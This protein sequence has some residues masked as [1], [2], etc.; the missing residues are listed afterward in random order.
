MDEKKTTTIDQH[1]AGMPTADG[2][3]VAA[4]KS[5]P[6]VQGQPG[7]SG[8]SGSMLNFIAAKASDP[9]CDAGQLKILLE[10]QRM[11]IADD[12]REQFNAALILV[13]RT[14]PKVSKRGTIEMGAKGS[15]PFARWEDV[16]AVTRPILD[17]N[18][19]SV[20][21]SADAVEGGRTRYK[22]IFSHRAGHSEEIGMILPADTGPGRNA[23]QAVGSTLSYGKRYLVEAFCNVIRQGID[24]DG[25][26]GG[27]EF[28]NEDQITQINN[29]LRDAKADLTGFLRHY[30]IDSVESMEAKDFT[31]AMNQLFQKKKQNEAKATKEPK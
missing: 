31:T 28:I 10:M 20:R 19:F 6:A 11:V 16:D 1:G 13:Q 4:P 15:I 2:A 7:G 21:F 22:A 24:D 17:A 27:T 5:V 3:L 26:L 18:G 25:K 23:L 12:A 30:G 29:A 8:A 9:S 14:V